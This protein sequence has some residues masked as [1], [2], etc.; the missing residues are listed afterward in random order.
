MAA[1]GKF[2]LAQ[3]YHN[4]GRDPQAIDLYNQLTRQICQHGSLWTSTASTC[5]PLPG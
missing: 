1:L 3:L 2:A 4:T 5:R